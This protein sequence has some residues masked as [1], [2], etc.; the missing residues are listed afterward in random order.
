MYQK[1]NS[2]ESHTIEV[3]SLPVKR[4]KNEPARLG[5]LLP[6]VLQTIKNRIGKNEV[7]NEQR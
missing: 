2:C 1:T 4:S 6:E 7:K 5:E 3:K